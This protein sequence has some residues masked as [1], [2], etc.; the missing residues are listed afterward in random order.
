MSRSDLPLDV[1]PTTSGQRRVGVMVACALFT[2][3]LSSSLVTANRSNYNDEELWQQR[4]QQFATGLVT[5]DL[6]RLT[7]YDV[8]FETTSVSITM[9]GAPTLWVGSLVIIA[10]CV[11]DTTPS[12]L[13]T[14]VEQSNGP[15]LPNVHRAMALLGAALVALLWLVSRRLLGTMTAL[16]A[17]LLIA[18]E[19]FLTALRTMFHTD[20]LVMSFS[21]IGFVAFCRALGFAGKERSPVALGA[22]AGVTLGFAGLTKLSAAAVVPALAVCVIWVGARTWQRQSGSWGDRIRGL[23]HSRLTGVLGACLGAGIITV[24][25]AWPA[26]V[27]DPARQIE[28]LRSSARLMES[29]HIQFFRGAVTMAPPWYYYL[30]VL[31]YRLTPWSFLGL[32]TIPAA[33]LAR[34]L[35]TRWLLFGVFN[36]SQLLVIGMSTKKFDRYSAALVAGVLVLIAISTDLLVG[37]H[38]RRLIRSQPAAL[39]AAVCSVAVIVLWGHILVVADRDFTYFNPMVGGLN[40]ASGDLMVSWGEERFVANDWLDE[41][42]GTDNYVLCNVRVLG[43]ICPPGEGPHVAVT[44][45]S[46]TQ[47][48]MLVIPPRSRSSWSQIGSHKIGDVE[49]IQFWE[50][51]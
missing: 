44:Y 41:R 37:D 8:N 25:V 48:D 2:I 5:G 49:M 9:P 29:G 40:S 10:E 23:A 46:N 12:S 18:T 20:S 22:L 13:R 36:A 17:C 26:L 38:V 4:S 1:G 3:A 47:R 15:A 7:A 14:C 35:D 42:F 43:V 11:S 39:S 51:N 34:R 27:V 16:L 19:P 28:A 6:N 32:L 21:L 31:A 45:L 50:E 30:W 33:L 24:A